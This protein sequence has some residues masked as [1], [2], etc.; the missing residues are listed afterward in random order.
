MGDESRGGKFGRNYAALVRYVIDDRPVG[1]RDRYRASFLEELETY[2]FEPRKK[3]LPENSGCVWELNEIDEIN[4]SNP[5]EF[6]K[7]VKEQ[8]HLMYQ[9]KTTKRVFDSL[10]RHL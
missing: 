1:E 6:A 8:L 5:V 9:K 3:G 10:I 7:L 2:S 4:L